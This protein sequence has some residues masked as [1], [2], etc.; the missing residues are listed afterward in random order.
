MIAAV[1]RSAM[2]PSRI[3]VTLCAIA[4][5]CAPSLRTL[6][7]PHPPRIQAEAANVV[8]VSASGALTLDAR[9]ITEADL[10]EALR[11][12][13]VEAAERPTVVTADPDAP[14]S[15]YRVALQVV[16]RARA[17]RVIAAATDLTPISALP[18]QSAS[19]GAPTL[20][21]LET[22]DSVRVNGA[23]VTRGELA[24]RIEASRAPGAA[25]TV[26]FEAPATTRF[27]QVATLCGALRR[28]G[29]ERIVFVLPPSETGSP[30]PHE[31]TERA[32]TSATIRWVGDSLEQFFPAEAIDENV[33]SARIVLA[34]TVEASGAISDATAV[35]DPGH[36]FAQAAVRAMTS[37]M[38][39]AT[40]A[41]DR[42]GRPV[43]S[44]VRFAVRFEL[45]SDAVPRR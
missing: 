31:P 5:G 7:R 37:G 8:R 6:S 23:S 25:P 38:F 32:G 39:T 42:E 11:R 27:A 15:V 45:A 36:G 24:E 35:S 19:A 34:V 14:F 2:K 12:R 22:D 21:A 30:A 33:A 17:G 29:V 40:P 44:V 20:V 3:S 43:R 9:A 26:L 13:S 18:I 41:R 1:C 16:A 10:V 28:S 4:L